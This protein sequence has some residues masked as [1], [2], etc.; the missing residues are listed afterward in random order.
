MTVPE[1]DA[2]RAQWGAESDHRVDQGVDTKGQ[3]SF[4]HCEYDY[5]AG[6]T[7]QHTCV[8]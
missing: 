6:F 2:S 7:L 5:E 1:G 3:W 4:K 8:Q